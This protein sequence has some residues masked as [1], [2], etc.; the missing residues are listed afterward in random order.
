MTQYLEINFKIVPPQPWSEILMAELIGLDFDSFQETDEGL[1]AYIDQKLFN[2]EALEEVWLLHS[3]KAEVSYAISEVPNIN[4]NAEWEKNFSPILI[5][6]KVLIRAEFHP[7]Q[8][9]KHE[10]V[11]QPKMAFGTGHH[12]TTNLMIS[13]MLQMDFQDKKVLDMGCGTLVLGIFAKQCGAASVH[14]IDIDEWAV[15][16]ARENATRNKVDITVQQGTAA[17]LGEETYDIILA[18]INRNILMQDIP[19]YVKVLNTGGLLLLSGLCDF[20]EEDIM[21]L[22]SAQGLQLVTRMQKE[23]WGSLLLKK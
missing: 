12:A 2:Q 23:E 17:Q 14:G 4:W 21:A 5:Q 8:A 10:I 18:N 19:T 7:S 15:D 9:G 13:Q 1:R 6:D 11:I 16:N 20:D 3:E 22:C